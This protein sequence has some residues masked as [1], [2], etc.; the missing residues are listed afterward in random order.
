M[1]VYNVRMFTAPFELMTLP[2]PSQGDFG[3]DSEKGK[4]ILSGCRGWKVNVALWT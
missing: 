3:A 2:L 1:I 4:T